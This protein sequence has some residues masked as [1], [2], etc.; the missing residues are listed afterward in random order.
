[1]EKDETLFDEIVQTEIKPDGTVEMH[2]V[3]DIAEEMENVR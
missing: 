2:L 3:S 1:M